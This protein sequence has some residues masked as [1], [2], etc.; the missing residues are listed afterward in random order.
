M[1]TTEVVESLTR[2][3]DIAEYW[4]GVYDTERRINPTRA[5]AKHGS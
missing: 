2:W 4:R 5:A 1:D 3:D